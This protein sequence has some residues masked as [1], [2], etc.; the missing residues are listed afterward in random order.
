MQPTHSFTS[1]TSESVVSRLDVGRRAAFITRTYNHLMGAI[2][3]FI[4][5]EIAIFKL[6]WAQG[7]AEAMLGRTWML[8]LAAFMFVSWKART[9]ARGS[10]S[11]SVQYLA[12]GGFVL[13]QAVIFVPLLYLA[14][15][16]GGSAVIESAALTT[17][18]GFSVLSVI[19]FYTRKDFQFIGAFLS[20][21]GALVMGLFVASFF[22]PIELGNW[23]SLAMVV[24]AGGAILYDTSNVLHHYPEDS[25]VAAALQLFA[26][27]ALLFW[28]V[29][30]L[31]MNRD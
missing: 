7:M 23:F 21:A 22:L 13:A 25:Y 20:F 11:K 18:L 14:A 12:L 30:R 10:N 4:L 28:Y 6:G 2:L 15:I 17:L 5:I 3:A 27:V 16:K 29:L 24:F 1:S 26:S 9:L 8:V 31:F 19:V